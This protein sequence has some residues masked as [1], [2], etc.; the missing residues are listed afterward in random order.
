V[1]VSDVMTGATITPR[2]VV[3]ALN[4]MYRYLEEVSK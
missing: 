4:L 1:K 3:T 2:A